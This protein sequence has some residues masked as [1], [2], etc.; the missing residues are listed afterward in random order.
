MEPEESSLPRNRWGLTAPESYVLLHGP[1]SRASQ[2][3]KLALLELVTRGWLNLDNV[4]ERGLLGSTKN[5]AVLTQ[6]REWQRSGSRPLDAV[7]ELF[8]SAASPTTSREGAPVSVA[9]VDVLPG[10][11]RRRYGSFEKYV[12]TEVLPALAR[13]GLYER[14]ER[15]VLKIFPVSRWEP[16][17]AGEAARSELEQN[18]ALGEAQFGDWVDR[19]PN[20]A[21]AFLGL[22]GSSALLMSPLHP[23]I[24]RLHEEQQAGGATGYAG[25]AGASNTDGD[26]ET[27]GIETVDPAD[28]GALDFDLGA[29]EGLA[30]AFSAIDAGVDSGGGGDTST[31]VEIASWSR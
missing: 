5:I 27:E 13:R 10:E 7:L 23:D 26:T 9:P 30:D 31:I 6:G 16:T 18:M 3:F 12:E 19:D 17:R 14:R 2:V 28:L 29:F 1:K 21:L 24:Q 22:A 15:R 8:A 4:E 11:Q 25:G 20:R